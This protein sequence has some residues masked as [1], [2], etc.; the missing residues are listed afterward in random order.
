VI[1]R[2]ALENKQEVIAISQKSIGINLRSTPL[3]YLDIFSE[4]RQL[5]AK[6]NHVSA[7]LFS[8]NSKGACPHCKGKGVIVS[9]MA[10]MDDIVTECEICHGTRYRPEVLA[11]TYQ[12]KTIVDI[13]DMTVNES[14]QFFAGETFA[15]ELTMLVEVGLGYLRL[16]QSLTTLSGGELQRLK[17]ANQLHKKGAFYLLDEPTDGLHLKDI[18]QLLDLFNRLVNQGNTLVLLEHHMSVIKRADW[19]IEIGPEGGSHGG[20]VMFAGTPQQLL[21]SDD[22][23]TKPYMS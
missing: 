23:I 9:D 6:E 2:T 11:Y 14:S 20:Q 5:F 7:A 3:T 22:Q 12:G 4:I 18:E 10:F 16:N 17:L 1:R 19:L 8:Y 21:A 15:K 13:L